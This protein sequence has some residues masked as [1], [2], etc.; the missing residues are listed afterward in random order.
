MEHA[1][2]SATMV[3]LCM[4]LSVRIQWSRYKFTAVHIAQ[5]LV[6]VNMQTHSMLQL[7]L[8]ATHHYQ[9]QIL[10]CPY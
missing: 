6:S 1:A 9:A 8:L 5:S 2:A 4:V 3:L 7:S 10:V